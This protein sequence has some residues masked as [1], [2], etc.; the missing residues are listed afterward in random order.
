MPL[1]LLLNFWQICNRLIFFD[2]H[3][4]KES[5]YERTE[6]YL[7]TSEA[8]N[9]FYIINIIDSVIHLALRSELVY[10]QNSFFHPSCNSV[11]KI[12]KR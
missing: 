8:T 12:V 5:Y 4:L 2:L 3:L 11:V 9:V 6:N 1:R 10:V 7:H